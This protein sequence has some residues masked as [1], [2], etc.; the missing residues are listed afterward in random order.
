[1]L[2]FIL[3]CK[4]Q[5]IE[6]DTS[7]PKPIVEGECVIDN[8]CNGGQICEENECLSG[9]R[10]NSIEEAVTLLWDDYV[11]ETLSTVEDVDYFS[12][13]TPGEEYIRILIQTDYEDGDTVMVL[14]DPNGRV[15]TWSD[16][17]PT[18]TAV[19]SL[20]S[21]I[22]A[23]LEQDGTYTVSVEDYNTYF[24]T[25]EEF[26]STLYEYSIYLEDWSRHTS[27][28]DNLDTPSVELEIDQSN[29]WTSVGALIQEEGDVDYISIDYNVDSTHFYV[30]G[31]VN[32][33]GSDLQSLLHLYDEENNQIA[34]KKDIGPDGSIIFPNMTQGKYRLEITTPNGSGGGNHWNY[35]FIKGSDDET[36][37]QEEESNDTTDSATELVQTET[38]TSTDKPYLYSQSFAEIQSDIDEDWFLGNNPYEE[39]TL[40][41]CFNA[42]QYGSLATPTIEVYDSALTLLG[43]VEADENDDPSGAI[44]GIT[45]TQDEDFYVRILY[46]Q[47]NSEETTEE[48]TT[49][50]ETTEEE[51]TEEETTEEE[52]TEE[53]TTLYHGHWYEFITYVATFEPTSYSCP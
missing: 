41:V 36:Y 49:E 45:L 15:V 37:P 43:S 13:S 21:V 11:S 42:G 53:E 32:L 5:K 1:M 12:F 38:T 7:D 28:P 2:F 3:A 16:D 47:S 27:E 8:D 19:S 48:E 39:A 4:D 17:F 52:T 18:G 24:Q 35:F 22:Y 51:T 46:P 31:I 34:A 10:N 40:V 33:D 25:G 20:D 26:G 6:T 9:D 30:S 14:R 50:E 23:Y 29:S 44:E